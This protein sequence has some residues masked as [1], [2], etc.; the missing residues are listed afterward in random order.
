MAKMQ[1]IVKNWYDSLE[2]GKVMGMKCK[3]CGAV[4]FPP[5]PICNKCSCMDMDWVEMDGEGELLSVSY[6]PIGIGGYTLDPKVT[7]YVRLKEGPIYCAVLN[8][9]AE[10]DQEELMERMKK[11]KV[12]TE[13]DITQITEK[14]KFPYLKVK[15]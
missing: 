14:F 5:V 10:A 2:K 13:F 1:S 3:R 4:E 8:D 7:G 11:G 6:S 15:G 9:V 12:K